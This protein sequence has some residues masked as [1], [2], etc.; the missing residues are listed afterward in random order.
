MKHILLGLIALTILGCATKDPIDQ[1]TDHLNSQ[2]GLWINGESPYIGLP[3]EATPEQVI[4]Q[5]I[6]LTGFDQGQI[7]TYTIRE[8]RR[9]NLNEDGTNKYSAILLDSDCGKKIILFR[10][11]GERLGWW[12]RFYDAKR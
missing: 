1:L 6:K 8:M 4:N 2:F 7:K 5:A 12:T 10:Y 11:E 3:P 9:V